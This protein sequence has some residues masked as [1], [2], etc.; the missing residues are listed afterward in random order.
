[1]K[2]TTAASKRKRAARRS[3]AP[4]SP[5]EIG[6]ARKQHGAER[7]REFARRERAYAAAFKSAAKPA[8]AVV[9]GKAKKA[10]TPPPLQILAEGDSWFDYPAHARGGI[11]SRLAARIDLPIRNLAEAGDEVRYMLG[12]EQRKVLRKKL[13]DRGPSG[14]PWDVLLF[15]GGG[16]D[17]VGDPM[18]LWVRDFQPNTP[19][20]Q[21]IEPARFAAALALVRAGYEDLIG[22]RDLHS[23]TTHL[24]FHAYDFA[25]PDNRGVCFF[26][27]WLAP[28]FK[29]RKFPK[30]SAPSDACAL[31]VREML[32]R[33]AAMLAALQRPNVSF[34]DG[35]ATLPNATSSWHNELHPS[36]SGFDLFVELFRNELRRLF[37]GRVP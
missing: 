13:E 23:P 8:G 37:P 14:A 6:A 31:V 34:L 11:I 22:L 1:M 9:A 12:V 26:G 21:L 29:L 15:S 7:K 20:A 32:Q 5:R 27:P 19:P 10:P 36:S 33:F 4:L 16:N 25:L 24:V 35:Q 2:R 18:A 28:T 3:A 30:F 17:I